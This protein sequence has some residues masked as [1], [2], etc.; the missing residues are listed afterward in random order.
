MAND[1]VIYRERCVLI[2]RPHGKGWRVDIEID[3][4]YAGAYTDEDAVDQKDAI[5]KST[6]TADSLL[7]SR[8]ST[9]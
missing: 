4:Q 3:G 9:T 5:Q 2:P 8:N 6:R 1:R 7:A